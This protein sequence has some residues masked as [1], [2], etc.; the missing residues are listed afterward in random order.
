MDRRQ[1]AQAV[2]LKRALRLRLVE[3][4]GK[5]GWIERQGARASNARACALR[6]EATKLRRDIKEAE[7]LIARL[8]QLY[9]AQEAADPSPQ[10]ASKRRPVTS[11]VG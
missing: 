7:F 9:L 6:M 8:E 10:A 4:N 3:M 5:V 2:E 1:I 11:S